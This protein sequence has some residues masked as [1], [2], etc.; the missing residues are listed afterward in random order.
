VD[1]IVELLVAFPAACT[2]CKSLGP[3]WGFAPDFVL[4]FEPVWPLYLPNPIKFRKKDQ[5]GTRELTILHRIWA[6][7]LLRHQ[8][9]K[10]S[11]FKNSKKGVYYQYCHNALI[12]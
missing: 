11:A 4:S 7:D 1:Q 8:N 6:D 3:G 5:Q 10:L 12:N 2:A 9:W